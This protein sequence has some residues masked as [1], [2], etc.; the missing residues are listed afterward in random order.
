MGIFISILLAVVALGFTVVAAIA[1]TAFTYL[2]HNEAEEA[3]EAHPGTLGAHVLQR[4]LDGDSEVY[5]HPLRLTR[6]IAAAAAVLATMTFWLELVGVQALAAFLTLVLVAFVGYPVLH[7]LARSAGRNRPVSSIRVLARPVHYLSKL[8]TPVTGLLDQLSTRIAPAR[9]AEAPAGVFE[10]EELREFLERASDAE[11]IEDDEAQMV[12]SVFEMDDLRIRSLMVPRTDMLTVGRDVP[13][14]EALSLFLRSGYSRM[15]VIGDS[16]DEIL[17]ILY[18]KDS[19]RAYILHS[20]APEGT[21]MPT[22]VE[23]MRPAR[24]EPETK[25]AMDLL[26]DMQRESTHVAIVVDEYGGT[27][28][29]VTLEDL[30]EELVGDISD[31]YDHE[32]PEYTLND[33]GTFRLSARLGIDELGEIFGIDLEDEDVDTVGGLLAKH[34]GMVPIVGSEIEIDG[35]HIRAIGSS[36]RRHQ[37]DMLQAWYE[38]PRDEQENAEGSSEAHSAEVADLLTV[39]TEPPAVAEPHAHPDLTGDTAE[40]EPATDKHGNR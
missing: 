18:L 13:L 25:R 21:P 36:G 33:D 22:L 34:L 15:P 5:T 12:K 10:E 19:M 37:V 30:I 3:V 40:A 17:G 2:P 39:D 28:G 35:I 26:R 4:T 9:E 24:F 11:T 6:L 7:V 20:E 16:S 32:R 27:A 1:E 29:L 31:E 8:L 23:I 38:P 14:R